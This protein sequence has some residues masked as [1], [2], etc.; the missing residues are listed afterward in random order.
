MPMLVPC[1]KKKDRD[2][3]S[4][5]DERVIFTDFDNAL[6][7][8]VLAGLEPNLPDEYLPKKYLPKLHTLCDTHSITSLY[9]TDDYLGSIYTSVLAHERGIKSAPL[10]AV[11]L[12]QH[13]YYARI[14]QQQ[15]ASEVTPE[16]AIVRHDYQDE[17][18]QLGFPFFIKPVKA[19]LSVFAQQIHSQK[20]LD[21]YFQ[22]TRVSEQ[23]LIPFNWAIEKYTDYE[24]D[25]TYFIAEKVLQGKQVTLEG[26][27]YEGEV[28]LIGIVDSVLIP[29]TIS[30]ERFV[31]PSSLSQSVQ[32]RMFESAKKFVSG[33]ELDMTLFN[34]EYM[35]NEQTDELHIIEIN[36]R[37][38]A[39]FCDLFAMVNGVSNYDVQYDIALGRKPTVHKKGLFQISAS[40]VG[41]QLYDQKVISAPTQDDLKNAQ[42]RFPELQFYPW[43]A[44]GDKLSDVLQDGTSYVY[45][46]IHLGA[47]NEHE[48]EAKY[49]ESRQLLPFVFEKV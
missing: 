8:K 28:G 12:C 42:E 26:Y 5:R 4:G 3:L 33:I 46:W 7:K 41:R 1:T 19:Y 15:Y 49:Q 24:Y 9:N 17:V 2:E 18:A 13:K 48:L 22:K 10:G 36:P 47:Q 45:G 40:L 25:G 39:Q 43:V 30:F 29:N 34:I 14:A 27:I 6:P 44:T 32:E 16:F 21:E 20:E 31:Y 37:M 38:S 11:L 35:Y 23:F